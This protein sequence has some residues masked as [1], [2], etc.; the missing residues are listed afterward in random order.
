LSIHHV[1]GTVFTGAITEY[2][3]D[4][5]TLAGAIWLAPIGDRASARLRWVKPSPVGLRLGDETWFRKQA[6]C[7]AELRRVKPYRGP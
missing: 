7:E 5:F 2:D 1:Q 3:Y 6:D 4:E